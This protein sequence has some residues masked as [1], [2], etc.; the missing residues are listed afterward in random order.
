MGGGEWVRKISGI[1]EADF[2]DVNRDP[3]LRWAAAAFKED[4]FEETRGGF[5]LVLELTALSPDPS[6]A[7]EDALFSPKAGGRISPAS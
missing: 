7:R 1:F 5:S 3:A 4:R 2:Q 6:G